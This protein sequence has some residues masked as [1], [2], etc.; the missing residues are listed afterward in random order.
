MG[1][2]VLY[3]D[4]TEITGTG[5]VGRKTSDFQLVY[6]KVARI[7]F[8]NV[9]ARG[10]FKKTRTDQIRI[11]TKSGVS[12]FIP[13]DK[14]GEAFDTYLEKLTTFAKSNGVSFQNNLEKEKPE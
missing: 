13:R 1:K 6:D 3:V 11:I 2:V 7:Q 9:E 5:F 8:D 14:V 10:L 12:V 4:K